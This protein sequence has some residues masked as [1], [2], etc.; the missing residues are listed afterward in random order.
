MEAH[1]AVHLALLAAC[2]LGPSV[3][4]GLG[5]ESEGAGDP[6]PVA[7][8]AGPSLF[9][10]M[11]AQ[12]INTIVWYLPNVK[13]EEAHQKV[14]EDARK[15]RGAGFKLAPGRWQRDLEAVPE[16]D[17]V[18]FDEPHFGISN[19]HGGGYGG[20]DDETRAKFIE[21]LA[22]K[23]TRESLKS[24][25]GVGDL[26]KLE[27]PTME[28]ADERH[29]LWYEFV[30]FHN[31]RLEQKLRGWVQQAYEVV[32]KVPVYTV[33]SICSVDAGP[34]FSGLDYLVSAMPELTTIAVDPYNHIRMNSEYWVSFGTNLLQNASGKPVHVWLSTYHGYMTTPR[35]MYAGTMC[36]Y[37]NGAAGFGYHRYGHALTFKWKA[38][39][40]DRWAQI[41]RALNF[42]REN[43]LKGFK[44]VRKVALYY[45]TNTYYMRYFGASWSKDGGVWGAGYFAERTYYG[46][47]RNHIPADIITPIMG[48]E[49]KI[50]PRLKDYRVIILPGGIDLSD[51][52]CQQLRDWVEAG[53]TLIAT[54]A[55]SSHDQCDRPR[56][57]LGLQ[58]VFGADVGT[59]AKRQHVEIVEEH[60]VIGSF[61]KGQKIEC[62]GLPRKQF[63]MIA[64]AELLYV[65][66]PWVLRRL[67]KA[68]REPNVAYKL[69]AVK[70]L[71]VLAPSLK[72]EGATVLA[73][74]DDGSAAITLNQFGK[75]HALLCSPI[76]LT[77][78]YEFTGADP[79]TK[80]AT[81]WQSEDRLNFLNDVCRWQYSLIETDVSR[82][83]ELNVLERNGEMA[84]GFINYAL[85]PASASRFS[86]LLP[87]G[88]TVTRVQATTHE[89]TQQLDFSQ[90]GGR[91]IASLPVIPDVLLCRVSLK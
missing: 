10:E 4:V 70:E 66:T 17:Y 34:R 46:L 25:L 15:I 87:P 47:I 75:G 48:E 63:L 49:E 18:Y 90:E 52:E 80:V 5:Q 67:K 42:A 22:E 38:D 58:D 16:F 36:A 74:W 88:K 6:L 21:F 85:A 41:R 23:Y 53:G 55:C 65:V 19:Y 27:L 39:Y 84:V 8:F 64:E 78:G 60:P 57:R 56:D 51:V 72:S 32:P 33:F 7:T 69:D 89:G 14:V 71:E 28:Q 13:D 9:D 26:E 50:G 45:P 31:V 86:L 62:E 68:G 35:D 2:V 12:G 37:I 30:R 3:R 91:L 11:K 54:G 83:V 76:D 61:K 79:D 20:Y 44:S 73:N 40:A 29:R 77:I 59:E 43:S 1:N 24:E 81:V 82:E